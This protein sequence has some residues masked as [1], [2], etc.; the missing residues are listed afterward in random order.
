MKKGA[1]RMRKLDIARLK[2]DTDIHAVVD[3]LG[4]Q[5]EKRG[6]LT[7][8]LCPSHGDRH[9]GSCYLTEKGFKCFA[10]GAS[11]DMFKLVQV[12][13]DIGFREA[14]EFIAGIGGNI[15]KYEAGEDGARWRPATIS[16]EECRAIGLNNRSVY[17]KIAESY[18]CLPEY[19]AGS[20]KSELMPD[21][22]LQGAQRYSVLQLVSHNPMREKCCAVAPLWQ[23]FQSHGR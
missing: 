14:A 16:A 9:F 18:F 15:E 17:A 11:G 23:S 3:A 8:I 4:L 22:V 1:M 6:H 20:F 5:T 10:C 19:S 12:C 21:S 2:D 7:S 13:N